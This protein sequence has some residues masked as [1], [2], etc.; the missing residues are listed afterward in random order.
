MALRAPVVRVIWV[1]CFVAEMWR[2]CG[3]GGY[4]G[5]VRERVLRGLGAEAGDFL[6]NDLKRLE[7]GESSAGGEADVDEVVRERRF[8]GWDW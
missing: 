3:L 2:W 1:L 4:Q 7:S 8:G 6:S 5:R